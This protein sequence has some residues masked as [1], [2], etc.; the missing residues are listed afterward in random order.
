[1]AAAGRAQ[2]QQEPSAETTED[3]SI[4]LGCAH[5]KIKLFDFIVWYRHLPG[6]VPSYL[7]QTFKET[8]EMQSP[9]GRLSVAANRLSSTL[10]LDRPRRGD[11]GVYYCALDH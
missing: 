2:V 6:Q 11:A 4:T 3:T 1:T 10:R 7:I 9:A 5:P 8:Q